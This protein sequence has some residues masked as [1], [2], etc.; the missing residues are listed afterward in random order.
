MKPIDEAKAL[1]LNAKPVLIG[2]VTYLSLGKVQ[3][4]KNPDF[5]P[6]TLLDELVDVYE[7]II[8]KLAAAGAQWIQ[9]DEPG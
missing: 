8:G 5:D 6:F 4:S 3:D 2:P 9:L 1:G 7:E